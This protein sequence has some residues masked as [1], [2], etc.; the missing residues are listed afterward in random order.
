MTLS[1]E[2]HTDLDTLTV[3][4]QMRKVRQREIKRFAQ[5]HMTSEWGA[6]VQLRSS[7][8]EPGCLPLASVPLFNDESPHLSTLCLKCK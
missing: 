4:L 8:A 2:N 1:P 6:G 7:E 5:S 3:I